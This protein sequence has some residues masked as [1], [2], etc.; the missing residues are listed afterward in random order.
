MFNIN[1]YPRI[2]SGILDDQRPIFL[3][4]VIASDNSSIVFIDDTSDVLLLHRWLN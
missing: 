3:P 1:Q 4:P 2:F